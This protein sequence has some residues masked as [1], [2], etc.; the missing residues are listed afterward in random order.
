MQVRASRGDHASPSNL[1]MTEYL[2]PE[3]AGAKWGHSPAKGKV[4]VVPQAD[5]RVEAAVTI[6]TRRGLW[7]LVFGHGIARCETHRKPNEFSL[8]LHKQRSSRSN[9]GKSDLN[10]KKQSPGLSI[11]SQT[12]ASYG[13][14]TLEMGETGSPRG[15][16]WYTTEP[17]IFLPIFPKGICGLS[18]R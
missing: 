18:S 14:G 3:V 4:G 13:H 8:D 2:D 6:V 10:H 5:T 16:V 1:N 9:E 17:L 12:R 15:R 11:N 7:G